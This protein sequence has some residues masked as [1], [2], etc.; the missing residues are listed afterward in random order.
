M[1]ARDR[2]IPLRC[3]RLG[4][5]FLL[6]LLLFSHLRG[7]AAA[8]ETYILLAAPLEQASKTLE[9]GAEPVFLVQG[10][11]C[12]QNLTDPAVKRIYEL[13]ERILQ[14]RELE[15]ALIAEVDTLQT[16]RRRLELPEEVTPEDAE[17]LPDLAFRQAFPEGAMVPRPADRNE[18]GWLRTSRYE[19]E[20][21]LTKTDIEEFSKIYSRDRDGNER[22]EDRFD[23]KIRQDWLPVLDR[24]SSGNSVTYG[25]ANCYKKSDIEVIFAAQAEVAREL[26]QALDQ[27]EKTKESLLNLK[28]GKRP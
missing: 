16:A 9:Q 13:H 19:C 25:L 3:R 18:D 6:G 26:Q 10:W 5:P 17:V 15:K 23:Q 12:G 8:D 2:A 11:I 7:T 14:A 22:T 20:R 21:T 27:Y 28:S 4:G 24:T 1:H